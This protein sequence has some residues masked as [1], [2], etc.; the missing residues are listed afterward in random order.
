MPSITVKSHGIVNER[1][2]NNNRNIEVIK[3][4]M[5]K[6]KTFLTS[7]MRRPGAFYLV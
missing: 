1:L 3:G 5:F 4:G 2:I 7:S 6:I